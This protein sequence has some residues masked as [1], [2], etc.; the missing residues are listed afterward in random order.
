MQR[1]YFLIQLGSTSV[2]SPRANSC[3]QLQRLRNETLSFDLAGQ[4]SLAVLIQK[5]RPT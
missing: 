2:H 5:L 1:R 4:L 3:V